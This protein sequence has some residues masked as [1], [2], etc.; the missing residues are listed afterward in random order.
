MDEKA[1]KNLKKLAVELRDAEKEYLTA[2][3]HIA[4]LKAQYQLKN[5]WETVLGKSRPTVAEK[6]AFITESLE[7]KENQLIELQ[8]NYHFLRELLDIERDFAR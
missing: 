8:A 1:Y 7:E 5:D 2:K 4:V 6:D 3:H